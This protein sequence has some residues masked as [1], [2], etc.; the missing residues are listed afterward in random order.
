MT[1]TN[2]S[3]KIT[4]THR[5][6]FAYVYIR[7][8]TP[9]QLV[10]H[11]E[12]TRRQYE[13]VD[14]AVALGWPAVRVHVIDED[15]AKSGAYAEQRLGF[16]HLL[17][18]LS[19]GHVGVV[20]SLEATRLSRNS[21][22]WY[23]LLELS[24]IFGVLI[25]DAEFIYD[26]H[27]YHDRLLL[28]LAGMMSEAELHYQHLRMHEGRRHKAERGALR[29]PLPAGLERLESGE[30]IVHP[31]EEVQAR[32]RLVFDT[33]ER[34]GSARA[35]AQYLR[36]HHLTL[37]TRL[38]RGPAPFP[39]VWVDAK[40]NGV[41]NIL[42]NP[43]YA[44]TYAWGRSTTDPT[45]RKPDVPHSGI[46]ERPIA[47]WSVC[48]FDTYPAYITWEQFIANRQRLS[49]NQYGLRASPAGAARSGDALLQ[50]MAM[51][52]RCGARLWVRYRGARGH[53][54][55]YVCNAS[56]IALGVPRC[57]EVSAADV[58]PVVAQ[59]VLHALEPDKIALALEAFEA[60]ERDSRSLE[61]Q[62]QLKVERAR[63]EAQRAQRQYDAV[64]PDNRLVA[65]NLEKHWEEK[66]RAA[67]DIERQYAT[68]HSQ[69]H[70]ALSAADRQAIVALG[71]N[72]PALWHA[73]TTTPAD[74]KRIVR[75]VVRDVLLD[76]TRAPEKVWLQINW[77][78]GA[79]TQHWVERP[80]Q[81]Y[82]ELAQVESLRQRLTA[83]KAEGLT[84][85]VI[86]A[87]LN[88]EGYTTVQGALMTRGAVWYL[89]RRWEIASAR[90]ERR[91]G[92]RSQWPDGRYTLLGVAQ[93]IGVHG[94]TVL[95]WIARGMIVPDQAYKRGPIKIALSPE[96][97]EALRCHVARVRRLRRSQPPTQESSA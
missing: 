64:E 60:L 41:L 28:G 36:R 20:L 16:Q 79:T 68:W 84:D 89:R 44:G 54:P 19:L 30:V 5:A 47:E 18:E 48:L 3:H 17:G 31:D 56:A 94:R 91:Q 52:G 22:D 21:S 70:G 72:L 93:L 87:R 66:L 82:R 49:A 58:D 15:L 71:Q 33:F 40:T 13:L 24:S 35:V 88:Q 95:S 81:Y 1:S 14:R 9:S 32:L 80:V 57:Q 77:Q 6:K 62:W 34:L 29:L 12:S 38:R 90:Q 86:A 73:V 4:E 51:C 55:G 78:T 27:Q 61:R 92:S 96:Q 25:A 53:R 63:Y 59:L 2:T 65:R 69:R 75:L 50:G 26:P 85:P 39:I 45:R 74:R 23:R 8:S 11:A 10:H 43:A 97:I 37:P 67:E 46:V 7:Q 76:R 83:L 42:E